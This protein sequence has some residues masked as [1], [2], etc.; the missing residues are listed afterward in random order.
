MTAPTASPS[1]PT[2]ARERVLHRRVRLLVGAT[3]T[4]NVVEASVALVAG[5]A[6]GSSALLAFGLD[7]SVEVLSALI[8]AWQFAQTDHRAREQRAL[9]LIAVSF[10]ALAAYVTVDSLRTLTG[11]GEPDSSTVGIAL[12]AASLAIMPTVA[13]IQRRTGHELGSASV[14]ANSRQTLLCS[15]LSAVLLVGLVANSALGWSWADPVAALGIAVLALREGRE[16][17]R[18]DAC[19]TP[20]ALLIEDDAE[21]APADAC[22]DGGASSATS[23]HRGRA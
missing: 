2:P 20:V 13:W 9:R 11:G 4:Y 10:F 18:G 7:S 23:S 5:A 3:I 21:E 12:A 19:C 15:Y 16:A 14:V 6:A 22:C 1:A 8:V 17:W